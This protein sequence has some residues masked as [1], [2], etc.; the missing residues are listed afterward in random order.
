M[1]RKRARFD[2]DDGPGMQ[3]HHLFIFFQ[4]LPVELCAEREATP[5]EAALPASCPSVDHVQPTGLD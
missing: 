2:G 4:S 5:R 1:T 3:L